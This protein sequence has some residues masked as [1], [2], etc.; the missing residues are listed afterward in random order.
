[1]EIGPPGYAAAF[2]FALALAWVLTPLMLRLALRFS[3]LDVPDARKAQ[4]SP[5][6]YLGGVAIVLAFSAT[7]LVAGAVA[8]PNSGLRPLAAVLGVGVVL[9][10]MGLVDDLRGVSP[11]LRLAVEAAA[12][13]VVY[14]T[15]PAISLPGPAWFGAALTV[16]WVVAVTN[17]FNLLD[18][19]D[20]LSAGVAAIAAGAFCLIAALN[21]QYLVAALAAA[22]AG[23]ATGF[24]RHN[25]HPAKIYMGDAGS[26]FLGFLL[27]ALAVRLRLEDAPRAVALFVPV[28]VLG[29]ALLDTTLVT[30]DRLRHRLSPMN[31]GR[32]H[33]S[34]R[35]VWVGIPVPVSV[36]LIYGLAASLAFLAVLLAR[37][38]TVSG[39]L[40]VGFVL[41][42]GVGLLGLLSAV[43]VY[44]TSRQ[45]TA[46]LRVVRQHEPEPLAGAGSSAGAR[47]AGKG[48]KPGEGLG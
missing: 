47:S 6:P 26:L 32:D 17:A 5:V 21:G 18:N 3:A 46:M 43:P 23:C 48:A 14:L 20:G 13:L 19:M 4:T 38:D 36:G 11:Y 37:L 27:A 22:T 10:L 42:A 34:H 7:V 35:L 29:V 25:F 39:M 1:M 45:R 24:L 8:G 15:E 33:I 2:V 28:V 30:L 16:L 31:G 44:A 12:G 9:A 40:L 41:T